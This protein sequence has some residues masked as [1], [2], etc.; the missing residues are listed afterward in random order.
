MGWG[1]GRRKE[2]M[3]AGERRIAR[4]VSNRATQN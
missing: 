2:R 1:K 4:V 3:L